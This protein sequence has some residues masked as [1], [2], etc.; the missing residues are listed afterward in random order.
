MGQK[1]A[2]VR[3]LD[4]E[5]PRAEDFF[6][7]FIAHVSTWHAA[8]SIKNERAAVLEFSAFVN[9]ARIA[10]VTPERADAWRLDL[11]SRYKPNTARFRLCVLKAAFG[12]AEA[13]QIISENPFARLDLP[14]TTFGGRVISDKILR[15]F[16]KRLPNQFRN[17]IKLMLYTGMRRSEAGLL[18]WSE[19]SGDRIILPPHRTKNRKGRTIYLNAAARRCLGPRGSGRVFPYSLSYMNKRVTETRKALGMGQI[20]IHDMRHTAATK[21]YQMN[22]DDRALMETFGWASH[23]SAKPYH[24]VTDIQAK[25]AM[26]R[27]TY[28]L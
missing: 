5:T 16:F 25:R 19:V 8:G 26:Q 1:F 4:G 11:L 17:P 21:H 6:R 12:Y 22:H 10:E 13:L 15:A 3:I 2:I 27:L 7:R 23:N 18:D 20:R 14:K 24:H 9:N 28:S